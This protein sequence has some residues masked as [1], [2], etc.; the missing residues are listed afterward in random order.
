MKK[1]L[2]FFKKSKRIYLI[3]GLGLSFSLP[4]L[5]VDYLLPEAHKLLK[6]NHQYSRNIKNSAEIVNL[7]KAIE[8]SRQKK[9]SKIIIKKTPMVKDLSDL[10]KIN[11]TIKSYS[12]K[13]MRL[14]EATAYYPGP[15]CTGKYSKYGRT[16]TGK[17][18]RYGLVAVDPKVIP[19]GTELFIE[20]YG[21][22]EAA[23]IGGAIK[24]NKIDLCFTTYAEAK[25]YGRKKI[26]VYI[27]K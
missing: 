27:L 3:L 25:K 16:Y 24:G 12:Y 9:I 19:L 15:E 1:L 10:N 8:N 5:T 4:Q 2:S 21:K 23:D 20:G 26:K 11:S 22:A 18:A 14:M 7:I 13:E 17:K 6:A